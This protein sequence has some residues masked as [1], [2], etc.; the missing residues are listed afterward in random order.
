MGGVEDHGREL[1]H[2]G[3]EPCRPPGCL[4]ERG[5]A[6]GEKDALV[7]RLA[8]LGDG[9]AHVLRRDELPLFDVDGAPDFAAATSRSVWRQRKAGI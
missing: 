3:Q 2:D 7:A 9:V 8:H 4:A 5:S 1:A 6:L